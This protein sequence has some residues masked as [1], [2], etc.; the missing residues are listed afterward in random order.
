MLL[1]V[2]SMIK[3]EME[4]VVYNTW[5]KDLEIESMDEEKIILIVYSDEQKYAI[6]KR[7]NDLLF[8]TFKYV[9]NKERKIEAILK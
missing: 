5:I 4:R 6:E 1:I 9:T 8:H 3:I 2:K 7:F